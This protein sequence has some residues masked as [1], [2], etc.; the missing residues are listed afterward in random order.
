[1]TIKINGMITNDDDASIY[2]DWFGMNVVSPADVIEALPIDGTPVNLEIASNGGEVDPATEICTALRNYNGQ[3]T[4][5]VVAN[6]YSAGTI[7]AMGADTVQMAPGAKMMIHNASSGADGNYHDMDHASQMLQATNQAI[8]NIYASKTGR[9]S[10]EFLQL[11]DS[12]TWLD[13]NAAKDLGLADEIVDLVEPIT[14]AVGGF[15]IPYQALHKVKD[16]L[17]ENQQLKQVP[18]NNRQ[19]NNHEQLV[20]AKLAILHKGE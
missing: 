8:A 11:M 9:P 18:T 14:N 10:A 17:A 7:I 3:V 12:E 19:L 16:L 4:A 2:R 5:Q 15:S 13:A 1:M 6:A 20:A